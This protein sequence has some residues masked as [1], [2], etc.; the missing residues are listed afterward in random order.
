MSQPGF[1][2]SYCGWHSYNGIYKYA[3][4]GVPP[5]TCPGCFLYSNTP[6]GNFGVDAAVSVIAH[7][8]AEA[9]T[10]PTFVGWTDPVYG[11]ENA[12]MVFPLQILSLQWSWLQ[13]AG[14]RS[15]LSG[16]GQLQFEHCIL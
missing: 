13:Y 5:S 9:A 1:C 2:T 16:A 15:Q 11:E 12:D 14:W 8:L 6:N 4:I 3:W 7:E 10:D